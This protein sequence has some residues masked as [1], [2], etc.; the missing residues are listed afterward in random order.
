MLFDVESLVKCQP[1]LEARDQICA[2][3]APWAV[4]GCNWVFA[5]DDSNY[6]CTGLVAGCQRQ[7]EE[8]VPPRARDSTGADTLCSSLGGPAQCL[9]ADAARAKG[10]QF[11]PDGFTGDSLCVGNGGVSGTFSNGQEWSQALAAD[12]MANDEY[13][14]LPLSAECFTLDESL[15]LVAQ[16]QNRCTARMPVWGVQQSDGRLAFR[17]FRDLEADNTSLLARAPDDS[18]FECLGDGTTCLALD[19]RCLV[20]PSQET[21]PCTAPVAVTV[22]QQRP[23]AGDSLWIIKYVRKCE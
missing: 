7:Y 18:S 17:R 2:T 1:L 21:V 4:D 5:G 14:P 19:G 11:V 15:E 20:N 16:P 6:Y 23:G 8:L 9:T 10:R 12:L 22:G 3:K 13:Q